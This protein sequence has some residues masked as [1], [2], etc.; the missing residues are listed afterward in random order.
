MSDTN[1]ITPS[2]AINDTEAWGLYKEDKQANQVK[3]QFTIRPQTDEQWRDFLL[4]Y[5]NTIPRKGKGISSTLVELSMR[6][7]MAIIAEFQIEDVS[8]EL[9]TVLNAPN[10][11][12][13]KAHLIKLADLL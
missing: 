5:S 8:K 4:T 9:N 12:D 7:L 6:I 10:K 13:V 2:Y 11:Q 3:R 1:Q